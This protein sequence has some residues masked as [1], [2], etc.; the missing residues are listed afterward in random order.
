MLM[1]PAPGMPNTPELIARGLWGGESKW[2]NKSAKVKIRA[3]RHKVVGLAHAAIPNST[4][5]KEKQEER[6]HRIGGI[7]QA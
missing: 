3:G 4:K 6:K 1:L 7:A 2:A 5:R